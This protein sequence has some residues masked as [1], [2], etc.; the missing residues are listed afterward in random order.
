MMLKAAYGLPAMR[1]PRS[2]LLTATTSTV[3]LC[4]PPTTMIHAGRCPVTR[5]SFRWVH[6]RQSGYRHTERKGQCADGGPL[7]VG[8]P[9]RAGP[10]RRQAIELAKYLAPQ[11]RALRV[12]IFAVTPS[13]R[14]GVRSPAQVRRAAKLK[15]WQDRR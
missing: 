1:S 12:Q 4:L 13:R 3:R 15:S 14:R 2:S 6:P 10:H 5:P 8:Y 11:P 7:A 9:P